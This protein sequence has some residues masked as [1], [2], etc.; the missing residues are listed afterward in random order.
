MMRSVILMFL[1]VLSLAAEVSAQGT[2]FLI[3]HGER[4]D[5][6]PG[7]APAVNDDP[8]LSDAGY[9]RAASLA[10]VLKDAGIT[11][12]FV[13]EFKR[14]QQT[15]APL[16]K[17]LGITATSIKGNDTNAVLGGVKKAKGNVL[18]IG[19][20]NTLPEIIKALG[21]KTAVTIGTAEFDNLYIVSSHQPPQ[22]LHL[23]Y[24]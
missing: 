24:R 4:A 21:I 13:T 16:A 3:R 8:D 19:H 2:V 18:I 10:T 6:V 11:A 5:A 12:I 1:C 7:A 15:G 9:A 23:H 22:L 14:T 20:S 17:L